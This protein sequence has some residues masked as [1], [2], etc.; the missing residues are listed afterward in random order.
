MRTSNLSV[1]KRID[2]LLALVRARAA[3]SAGPD[4]NL[5]RL[6][7]L[8]EHNV[9]AI[10]PVSTPAD[11]VHFD[12]GAFV[13][14]PDVP[15]GSPTVKVTGSLSVTGTADQDVL[16]ELVRDRGTSAE[17][18]LAQQHAEI[19]PAADLDTTATLVFLD[20]ASTVDAN[21][22]LPSPL[23]ELSLHTWSIRATAAATLTGQGNALV[24]LEQ[25][26]GGVSAT[27]EPV[28]G[29]PV[30]L[31]TAGLYASFA[32]AG[33]TTT[34]TSN[35]T[36]DLGTPSTASSLTGWA[37]VLDGSGQF[38][39]SS[40]VTG[41]VY[42]HDYAVPTPAKVTQA[43]VDM[44]AAYTDASTRTPGT[45]DD[46]AGHLGGKTLVPG[47]YKWTTPVEI[48]SAPAGNLTLNGAGVYIFQ[49]A[50]T[51]DLA[52]AT[53][54]ILEGGALAQNVFWAIAGAVTLHPGSTFLGELLAATSI[55]AQAG[56][57]VR[58]RLLAQ[59]GVT[60]INNTIVET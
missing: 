18:V 2:A 56:A 50:G 36:G 7:A 49:I 29:A 34:G 52:A 16:V 53:S 41:D 26:P 38:S 17:T 27:A 13:L 33:I 4:A 48:G 32:S 43:N 25:R 14:L 44:L 9:Q 42:A 22:G 57:T 5:A 31:G 23:T 28:P 30:N 58:G 6:S 60:L 3:A 40:Q 1:L 11:A 59:T 8:L 35:V 12:S 10:G 51:F 15:T 20:T 54:I 37:L 39:T 19:G 55:A 47:V 45:T 46:F 21:T 24:L